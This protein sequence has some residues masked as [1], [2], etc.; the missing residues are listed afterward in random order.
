VK[1]R[2]RRNAFEPLQKAGALT[3]LC[4]Q[5]AVLGTPE[6]VHI[7]R[8]VEGVKE[9]ELRAKRARQLRALRHGRK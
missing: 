7:N 9:L 6:H 8:R 4:L 5:R 3:A 2:S 1:P